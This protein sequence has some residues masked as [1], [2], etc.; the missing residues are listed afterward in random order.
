[1]CGIHRAAG[2]CKRIL[3]Q[4]EKTELFL[5]EKFTKVSRTTGCYL[6]RLVRIGTG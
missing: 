2:Q 6:T 3:P 1:L 4:V 5:V